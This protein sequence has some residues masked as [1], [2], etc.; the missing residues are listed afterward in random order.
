MFSNIIQYNKDLY[1]HSIVHSYIVKLCKI[2][3]ILSGNTEYTLGGLVATHGII[4]YTLDGMVPTYGITAYTLGS[5]VATWSNID[6]T[7]T[8]WQ[9]TVILIIH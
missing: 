3:D 4:E 2:C 6:Y 5:M 7:L 8:Q 9:P 1:I